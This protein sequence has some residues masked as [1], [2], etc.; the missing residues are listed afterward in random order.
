MTE[1]TTGA[2]QEQTE[3]DIV[4]GLSE[5]IAGLLCYL[6]GF[7][8]GA[9][10]YILEDDNEFVRFHAAQSILFGLILFALNVGL[11]VLTPTLA[12]TIPMGILSIITAAFGLVSLVLWI[13]LMYKAYSGERYKLPVIGDKAT[14]MV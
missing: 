14:G 1:T 3:S 2:N 9:I 7:I 10:F 13:F 6:L 4:G 8:T 12:G 5:N 11:S